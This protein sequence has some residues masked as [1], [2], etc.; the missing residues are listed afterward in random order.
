MNSIMT[1]T[2]MPLKKLI[3]FSSPWINCQLFIHS[4]IQSP[5][6]VF[7]Q[8]NSSQ[9]RIS[10]IEYA[11]ITLSIA[12]NKIIMVLNNWIAKK[13]TDH[14]KQSLNTPLNSL[15]GLRYRPSIISCVVKHL[16][17]YNNKHKLE[18]FTTDLIFIQLKYCCTTY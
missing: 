8:M 18:K 10:F 11:T 7:H 14:R 9:A 15:P 6:K 17:Y 4:F 3:F 12:L 2:E 1:K 13:I 5:K 16:C